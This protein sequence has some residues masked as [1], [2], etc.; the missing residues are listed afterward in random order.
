MAAAHAWIVAVAVGAAGL[1]V[2]GGRLWATHTTAAQAPDDVYAEYL[3]STYSLS[4]QQV[5][6]LRLVLA[7]DR[8]SNDEI[9][10]ALKIH[11][12]PPELQARQSHAK[13]LTRERIRALLDDEQRRRYDRDSQFVGP[14]P[15]AQRR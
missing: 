4:R 5:R 1:G 10:R 2:L 6:S 15:A 13:H 3:I 12:L 8:A 7:A 14:E 9:L 11:E